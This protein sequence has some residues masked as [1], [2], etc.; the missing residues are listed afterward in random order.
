MNEKEIKVIGMSTRRFVRDLMRRPK[1]FVR[2]SRNLYHNVI[3]N[4]GIKMLPCIRS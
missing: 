4:S 1:A 2:T 3:N